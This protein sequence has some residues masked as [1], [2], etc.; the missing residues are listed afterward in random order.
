[1]DHKVLE[2]QNILK[3]IDRPH[4]VLNKKK[5]INPRIYNLKNT[6]SKDLK[7]KNVNPCK[8]D[9]NELRIVK[10]RSLDSQR[11]KRKKSFNI[12][13][14]PKIKI[15]KL[16]LKCKTI[17]SLKYKHFSRFE[18]SIKKDAS[19]FFSNENNCIRNTSR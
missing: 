8:T 17:K 18:E 6:E 3:I 7:I 10:N 11:M 1:M 12:K 4:S 14:N 16:T 9:K 15:K 13:K 5:P 2:K 19:R